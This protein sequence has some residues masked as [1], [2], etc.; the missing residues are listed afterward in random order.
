M[1]V[2]FRKC[3]EGVIIFIRKIIKS[4]M[5]TKNK[6]KNENFIIYVMSSIYFIGGLKEEEF[7]FVC[8]CLFL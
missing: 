4:E 5:Y 3:D 8:I 2:K 6:M 1:L 7:I